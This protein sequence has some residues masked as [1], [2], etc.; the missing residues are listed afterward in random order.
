MFNRHL[1]TALLLSTAL[2][3]C[4]PAGNNSS[5]SSQNSSSSQSVS[6]ESSVSSSS[7]SVPQGPQYCPQ[8]G[9]C[10]I[11]PLGDSITEGMEQTGG[12]YQFNGGY[13]VGLF[14]AAVNDGKSIT[15]VGRNENG[16]NTVAG[17]SFPKN[18][19]GY[20]G[21]T[22]QQ[23]D[24]IIPSPAMDDE[25][26]I[27]LLHI[28]TNDMF[29]GSNGA[30][31]RLEALIRDIVSNQPD[32]LLAV[33]NLIPFPLANSQTNGYNA[34]V[35]G[36]VDKIKSELNANIIF[37]DQNQGYPTS[38]LPDQVHPSAAGY[39]IMGEKWYDAIKE[40]LN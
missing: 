8:S 9:P 35:P 21:W 3:G 6:S 11:L 5:S 34:Q 27:I 20:S 39:K 28:G 19:E 37:V 38:E 30:T 12:G 23:I 29:Q 33:S 14:E 36:L 7:S 32:A 13:R 24:D 2:F 25:P 22:I 31:G 15:F 40:Y 16:P 10:K 4:V 17:Q 26:H 18:N 1:I